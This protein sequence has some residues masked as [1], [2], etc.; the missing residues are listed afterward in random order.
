MNQRFPCLGIDYYLNR[1]LRFENWRAPVVPTLSKSFCAPPSNDNFIHPFHINNATAI[2]LFLPFVIFH[3]PREGS[4]KLCFSCNQSFF[5][6]SKHWHHNSTCRSAHHERAQFVAAQQQSMLTNE[7]S[8]GDDSSSERRRSQSIGS[9]SKSESDASRPTNLDV[10]GILGAIIHGPPNK[11]PTNSTSGS[12]SSSS[13][14]KTKGTYQHRT[15]LGDRR[16]VETRVS[17]CNQ[18]KP[19]SSFRDERR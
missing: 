18:N 1:I 11:R 8:E 19:V 16:V 17:V 4:M 15:T 5:H 7:L 12:S 2:R 10:N 9:K 3:L 13:S 14:A 6:I